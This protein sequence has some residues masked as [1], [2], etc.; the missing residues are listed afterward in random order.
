[1][2]SLHTGIITFT[3][4]N[5]SFSYST[6][7]TFDAPFNFRYSAYDHKYILKVP[8]TGSPI[9]KNIDNILTNCLI[10]A[11]IRIDNI[12]SIVSVQIKILI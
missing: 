6:T 10:G 8:D 1:M 12:L 5:L 7:I 3:T 11:M 4:P 2:A 9:F